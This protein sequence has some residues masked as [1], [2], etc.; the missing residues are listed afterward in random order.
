M[1]RYVLCI[2]KDGYMKYISHLDMIRL[3]KN[4]FKK[5]GVIIAYSQGFNPHPRMSFAQPL[6]LGYSSSC[7]VLEIETLENFEPEEILIRINPAL[8]DGIEAVKC[9]RLESSRSLGARTC[10]AS[11]E[12]SIPVCRGYDGDAVELCEGYLGREEIAAV[13]HQKTPETD[14]T[15]DI[16]PMIRELSSKL[17]DNKLILYIRVDCGSLSNLSPELVISSFLSFSGIHADR[18]EID[19]KRTSLEFLI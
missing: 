4:C 3:F 15:I 10:A 1:S 9:D 12:I 11:Y 2:T 13:K 19:V 8:P 18:E 14:K 16:K 6:S 5:S 17:V 7:E